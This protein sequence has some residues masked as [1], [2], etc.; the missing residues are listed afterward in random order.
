M[1]MAVAVAMAIAV[2]MAMTL[3]VCRLCGKECHAT[4][5]EQNCKLLHLNL[6]Y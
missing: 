4:N 5:R 1:V 2:S 6:L 3:R